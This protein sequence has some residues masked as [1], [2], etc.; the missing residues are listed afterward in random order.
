MKNVLLRLSAVFVVAM[1][2]LPSAQAARLSGRVVAVA[3]GDTVTLLDARLRRHQI[4][5]LGIDAPE[6]D[7][8]YGWQARAHLAQQVFGRQVVADCRKT[9][10]YQRRLCRLEIDQQDVNL[11][12]IEA[13]LAWH[14][15]SYARDQKL[16]ERLLYATAETQAR[17]ARRGL[18]SQRAPLA[19]WDYRARSRG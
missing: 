19:P 13:G 9:D 17:L 5:L 2:A 8:S 18:W 15:K 4:R 3:D 7:Q 11:G 1:L 12:L 16:A 10:R 6:K 14:Y